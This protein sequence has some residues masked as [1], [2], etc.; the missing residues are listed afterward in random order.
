MYLKQYAVYKN[1][2]FICLGTSAECAEYLGVTPNAII[3]NL[4]RTKKDPNRR[5]YIVIEL[6]EKEDE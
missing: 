1:D 5:G 6:E 2:K 4:S 3:C